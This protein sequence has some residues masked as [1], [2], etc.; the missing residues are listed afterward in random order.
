MLA[1][2]R[3]QQTNLHE[4]QGHKLAPTFLASIT[5][6]SVGS[7]ASM[8]ETAKSIEAHPAISEAFRSGSL[9]EAKAKQIASAA[10]ARPD[11]ATNLVAAASQME[12]AGLKRH[13]AD[14]RQSALSEHD[15]IERYEQIRDPSASVGC[16]RILR[17]SEG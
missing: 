4:Q 16:G 10:D 14:V 15:S 3:V 11:Q 17:T 12:L 7:A 6:E 9:S 2:R 5:G 1:A 8:L 13:C